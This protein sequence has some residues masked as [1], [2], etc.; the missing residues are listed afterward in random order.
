MKPFASKSFSYSPYA[1]IVALLISAPAT[2]QEAPAQTSATQEAPAA[3]MVQI[4][5]ADNRHGT[6]KSV[7]GDVTLVRGDTRRPAKSGD[8]F[9]HTDRLLVGAKSAAALTLQDGT[10]L[11]V[12]PDSEVDL[13][14]F[15]YDPTTQ[16]GSIMVRLARGSL[17]MVTGLIAKLKPEEVSVRTP[18]AVIGVRG[19]DF[20]V[21]AEAP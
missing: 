7:Q 16:H 2:A 17:R 4:T 18:T 9:L 15:S 8:G 12:G 10:T 5:P 11:A 1:L 13:E 19:T 21:E 14:K 3:A 6:L 20:I